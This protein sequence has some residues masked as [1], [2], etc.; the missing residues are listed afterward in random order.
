MGIEHPKRPPIAARELLR[1]VQRFMR[2]EASGGIVLLLAAVAAIVWANSTWSDSYFDLWH[3][4]IV[5]DAG[6]FRIDE[7]LQ[8]W[9]ND[10]L[11]AVFFFVVGLEIKRELVLGELREPRQAA[12]PAAAA[13]GGMAAPA[14]LFII[15]NAGGDGARGWG[16]PMATDIAFALGV[17]ALLGNR[18]SSALRVFLLA[19][20][21]VDDIGAIL[22]I[23]IFYTES[24]ALDSLTIALALVVLIILMQMVDIR[25]VGAYL[26]VGAA[27]WIATFES[28]IHATIAGVVLGLLTPAKPFMTLGSYSARASDLL[29]GLNSASDAKDSTREETLEE[30]EFVTAHASS[31][32]TRLERLLHPWSS[33]VVL[34]LFALANAGIEISGG[35]IE[36]AASSPI[37]LGVII[38]LVVGKLTGI[39]AAVTVM[40]RLGGVSLPQGTDWAQVT[41]TALLAGIGFTVSLFITG[42][43]FD[44]PGLQDEAKIGILAASLIAGAAG[45]A[46]LRV[47]TSRTAQS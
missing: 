15:L 20:A 30:L 16:I 1:P 19:V 21:I 46:V 22:V 34:P 41:G 23:A 27:L 6:I 43:A 32:L 47:A 9:V 31:P 24:V 4:T 25:S 36:D 8:H 33:Y 45:Y 3:R 11:M 2:V 14:V 18:I 35:V 17:M 29:D 5:I 12:L 39:L 13:L 38:G 28:G 37:T 40:T 7:D 44:D 42:L 26:V 10:A